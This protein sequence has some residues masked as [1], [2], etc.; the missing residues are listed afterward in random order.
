MCEEEEKT[1]QGM[2]MEVRR[3]DFSSLFSSFLHG[4]MVSLVSV[5]LHTTVWWSAISW[6]T[7]LSCPVGLQICIQIFWG[8]PGI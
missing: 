8:I 4:S 5:V 3:A 2:C 1:C 6:V 7:I